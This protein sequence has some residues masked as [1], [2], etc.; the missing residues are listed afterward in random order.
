[1]LA[2]IDRM[3]TPLRPERTA[4]S[5]AIW[6]RN[7][8]AIRQDVHERNCLYEQRCHQAGIENRIGM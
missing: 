6:G 5:V 3:T 1:M 7:D 2:R 8:C 4:E